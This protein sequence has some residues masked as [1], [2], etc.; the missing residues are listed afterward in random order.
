M[1]KRLYFLG[2]GGTL[3]GSLAMLA[4]DLGFQVSGSD[5]QLYPPMS[6]LLATAGIEVFEGFHENQLDPAP[7]QIIIGNS[8][9]PRGN[10]A[11]EY[12]LERGLNYVSGAEWLGETILRDRWVLAV[13]GTH[14]KTTTASMLVWILEKAGLNPGF[15]I[16]GAPL[17]F[18]VSSRLGSDPFFVVEADEYDT[19]YFDR[20]S[21]F[22][23]YRPRTLVI[24]NLEFDHSDIFN[25]L[26]QIQTSFKRLI[27]LVP[28]NGLLLVNGDD[29]TNTLIA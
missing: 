6:D 15:L 18:G 4:K 24:N 25:D 22:V 23:H 11:I 1:S 29:K 5:D 19:S 12:I 3:I 16:G 14:G 9:L 8:G 2:I 20:R 13:S 21:K 7:A 10:P 27:N 26:Q 17:N 28:S